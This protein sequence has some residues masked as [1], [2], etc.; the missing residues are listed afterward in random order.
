MNV[1]NW[2]PSSLVR[3]VIVPSGVIMVCNPPDLCIPAAPKSV[4]TWS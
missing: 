1:K 2:S 3:F 4:H